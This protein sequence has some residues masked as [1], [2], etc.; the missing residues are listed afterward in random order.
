VFPRRFVQFALLLGFSAPI[1]RAA[2][3]IA[4]I[5]GVGDDFT[6]YT[7][8]YIAYGS[9]PITTDDQWATYTQPDGFIK[10]TERNGEFN[11]ET[12]FSSPGQPAPDITLYTDPAGY[13]WKFIA[14]TQSAMWPYT[15]GTNPYQQ[16]ATTTTPPAGTVKYTSNEKNQEMVFWAREGNDP[17]GAPILR[18][19]IT[20]QW[21]ND[22]ILGASGAATD[23][24]IP[25][26]IDAAVLPSGWTKHTGTLNDT[27]SLLPA[28]GAGNQ[29][30]YNLFRESGDNTFFQITWSATGDTLAN[31]IAGM[32]IWGGSASDTIRGRPGDD[33]LIHGAEG[34]D[35]LFDLGNN[36]T[37]YGDAGSDTIVLPGLFADYTVLDA[38]N[39]GAYLRLSTGAYEKTIY[40]AEFLQ[41]DDITLS[42]AAVPEPAP[43]ALAA[44]G[45]LAFA[46]RQ[47]KAEG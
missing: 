42:T 27:L 16:A 9:N 37:L 24:D 39:S 25:A 20:D 18:Y 7:K 3:E 34:D 2:Y 35:T 12:T 13:T 29:A 26:S 45:L 17:A 41:F 1:A 15:S 28:Y 23:A 6:G 36:D 11:A 47:R 32:P 21:G 30:H 44:L 14:Q 43:L 5:N 8:V 46:L 33:N 10:N 31:Q 38:Q 4:D 40:D 22:Y 19:Y